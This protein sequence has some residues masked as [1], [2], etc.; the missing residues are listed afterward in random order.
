MIIANLPFYPSQVSVLRMAMTKSKYTWMDLLPTPLRE[1]MSILDHF[2]L[3]EKP[4]S[5]FPRM[6]LKPALDSVQSSKQVRI[7]TLYLFSL[8]SL[9]VLSFDLDF[10]LM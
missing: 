1:V 2:D 3:V 10:Q 9:G 8:C 5:N 7:C 6:A 4:K